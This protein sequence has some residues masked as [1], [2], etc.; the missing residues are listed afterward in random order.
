MKTVLSTAIVIAVSVVMLSLA[1]AQAVVPSQSWS[2]QF[3]YFRFT[4]LSQFNNQ[5]VLDKETGLVWERS[6]QGGYSSWADAQLYC[7]TLTVGGRSGWRLPTF[8]ELATLFDST[9]TLPN[10]CLPSGNPFLNISAGF[11][12]SCTSDDTDPL[13]AWDLF[14]GGELTGPLTPGSPC[15]PSN[16][17]FYDRDMPKGS[18]DYVWCV[19]GGSGVPYQ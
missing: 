18:P 15:N 17:Y 9:Q 16:D 12:W 19:R 8:Q 13:L 14:L 7:N 3:P 2:E 10:L 6:P 4:V 11:Y 5:A 1:H